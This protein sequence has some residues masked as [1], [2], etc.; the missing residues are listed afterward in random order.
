M[1]RQGR[2]EAEQRWPEVPEEE[3][4]DGERWPEVQPDERRTRED[5]REY[6]PIVNPYAVVALVAALLLLFPVALIFGFISYGHPRGRGMAFFA[7]LLGLLEVT[8]VVGA[9]V[10]AGSDLSD[11]VDWGDE[12]TSSSGTFVQPTVAT[13]AA[14]STATQAPSSTPVSPAVTNSG[15]PKK[16]STCTAAQVGQIGTAV[17]GSTLLCLVKASSESG[18]QWGG[19]YTVAA[20]VFESGSKCDP[21]SDK[22]GRTSDGRALVCEGQGR[23]ASWVPWTE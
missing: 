6:R 20:G 10:L 18:Y 9:V 8:A 17:D 14:P 19:P 12:S 1:A 2:W 11:A 4:W 7:I 23:A 15:T 13:T 21:S 3:R 16:G 5:N 22:T